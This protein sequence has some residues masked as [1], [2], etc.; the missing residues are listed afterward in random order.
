VRR[1]AQVAPRRRRR[2]LQQLQLA[3]TEVAPRLMGAG[4]ASEA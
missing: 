3:R 2:A 1:A 4:R